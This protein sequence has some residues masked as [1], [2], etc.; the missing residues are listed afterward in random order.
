MNLNLKATGMEW[1]PSLKAFVEKKFGS[2]QKFVERFNTGSTVELRVEV[3]KT[4]H[5]HRK[6]KV[7]RAEA[8]LRL[9]KA[10][11]RAEECAEDVRVAVDRLRHVLELEIKKYKTKFVENPRR[12]RKGASGV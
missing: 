9:P 2:L 12:F 6:G 11:L 7:F 4:T 5:H 3:E 8:N 1:T 10:L